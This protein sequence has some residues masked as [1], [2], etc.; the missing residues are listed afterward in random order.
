MTLILGKTS[1]ERIVLGADGLSTS[2]QLEGQPGRTTQQKLFPMEHRPIAVAQVG[3]NA[4]KLNGRVTGLAPL[5]RALLRSIEITG[6]S[7]NFALWVAGFD[8]PS[9]GAA[10]FRVTIHK[11]PSSPSTPALQAI[12][13]RSFK[14]GSGSK[15]AASVSDDLHGTFEAALRLQE[16]AC[17]F[18]FGGHWHSLNIEPSRP[19]MW[20]QPPQTGTL[21]VKKLLDPRDI[22]NGRLASLSAK[23]E[24][25]IQMNHMKDALRARAKLGNGKPPRTILGCKEHWERGRLEKKPPDWRRVFRLVAIGD[26]AYNADLNEVSTED[27][28]LYVEHVRELVA[29]L[30]SPL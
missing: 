23:E 8:T 28:L 14:D 21:G 7:G 3:A 5:L 22:S 9:R 27:A 17:N 15:Y 26:E 10:V 24:I 30:P 2:A 18:T 16:A 25:C 13:A 19:P 20:I 11:S 1:P 29:S 12:A 4:V 6:E